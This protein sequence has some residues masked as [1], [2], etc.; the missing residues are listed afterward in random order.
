MGLDFGIKINRLGLKFPQPYGRALL[1][2]EYY[3]A[4]EQYFD[5]SFALRGPLILAKNWLDFHIFQTTDAADVHVGRDDWLYSRK[6]VADYRK[7]AGG[8]DAQ[9]KAPGLKVD[10]PL[11]ALNIPGM[12]PNP[13]FLPL[14]PEQEITN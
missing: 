14:G 4:F 6:A 2:N 11:L 5:D 7:A 10:H 12:H 13:E 9:K 8:K 3:R 1:E